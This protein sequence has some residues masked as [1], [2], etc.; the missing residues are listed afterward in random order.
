MEKINQLKPKKT[1]AN[2]QDLLFYCLLVGLPV[3]QFC[4]FY[5]GVNFNSIIMSFKDISTDE[6]TGELITKF[7]FA[8]YKSAFKWFGGPYFKE[9]FGTSIKSF[10]ITTGIGLP[11]ALLFAYYIFKKLPGWGAFR[12]ILY[13]PQILSS[14]VMATVFHDF[15]S[16]CLPHIFSGIGDL[17]GSTSSHRFAIL[18]FFNIWISFG[19]N[20][21]MYSNKMAGISDEIIESAHLD[22]ATGLK[23]FWYI[24]LPL[25]YSTITVFLITGIAGICIN[26]YYVYDMFGGSNESVV[27]GLKSIGYWFFVD[28]NGNY[29]TD[30]AAA[31][32]SY[33]SAIG[34]L[35]T[36]F[37]VPITLVIRWAL[38][39]YGPSEE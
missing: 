2:K 11:L 1:K 22:G 16:Q 10:F 38:E 4:I 26:Q 9:Y 34:V 6:R 8:N 14:L 27:K 25:T 19:V 23:E 28:V 3:L 12:V 15:V 7:N 17:L 31:S 5:I 24:V 21:L 33:Y 13:L 30:N 36:I 35:L 20:V 18:M 39:K 32:L 29:A 37:T